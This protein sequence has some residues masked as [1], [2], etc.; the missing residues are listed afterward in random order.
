MKNKK[1]LI[2]VAGWLLYIL[3]LI[4]EL[5]IG[6]DVNM[7][8]WPLIS[9]VPAQMIAF[10]V[11]YSI[12][13]PLFLKKQ[14]PVLFVVSCITVI[15]MFVC[16]K[17]VIE[18]LLFPGVFV[19][20]PVSEGIFFTRYLKDNFNWGLFVV[21]GSAAIYYAE[22]VHG[23]YRNNLRIQSENA[24]WKES[25]LKIRLLSDAL[26]DQLLS[27]DPTLPGSGEEHFLRGAKRLG[28]FTREMMKSKSG[29][30]VTMVQETGLLKDYLQ[31]YKEWSTTPVFISVLFPEA[32][33]HAEVYPL[34]FTSFAIHALRFAALDD[35]SRP[36]KI[37]L[38]MTGSRAILEV[39]SKISARYSRAV[40]D[41]GLADVVDYIKCLY[42]AHAEVIISGNG[43]TLKVTLTLR[44]VRP[45]DKMTS[46]VS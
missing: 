2:H 38:Q 36:L 24:T 16:F 20:K 45:N 35:E 9:L 43:R 46:L 39:S 30:K 40:I 29:E 18:V 8:R 25:C 4:V 21:A 10:Y 44:N 28:S 6:G 11:C 31:L 37:R 32:V 12:L 34:S 19:V 41:E 33:G 22:A 1:W 3:L 13:Y 17:F 15:L 23:F 26:L 5:R 27:Y 42:G 7:V 14:E